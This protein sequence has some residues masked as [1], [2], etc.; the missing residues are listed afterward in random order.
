[1]TKR[2]WDG[3]GSRGSNKARC[4]VGRRFS[5]STSVTGALLGEM[6]RSTAGKVW[7]HLLSR[8]VKGRGRDGG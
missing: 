7:G 5:S 6:G 3:R 1:M 8:V 2:R 4:M